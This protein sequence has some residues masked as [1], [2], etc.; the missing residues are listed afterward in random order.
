MV[1]QLDGPKEGKGS[2]QFDRLGHREVKASPRKG[3]AQGRRRQ[4]KASPKKGVAKLRHHKE[5]SGLLNSSEWQ[6]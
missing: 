2:Q 5:G 4:V 3:V 1:G 6:Q